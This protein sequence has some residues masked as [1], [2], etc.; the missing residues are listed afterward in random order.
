MR[1]WGQRFRED[2]AAAAFLSASKGRP[3]A[4]IRLKAGDRYSG[5]AK[6]FRSPHVQ[7]NL[8]L[9]AGAGWTNGRSREKQPG[10]RTL[11]K[12]VRKHIWGEM[13]PPGGCGASSSLLI[14]MLA[15]SRIHSASI[16]SL[17]SGLFSALLL[18]PLSSRTLTSAPR[19]FYW[20]KVDLFR[21]LCSCW[22]GCLLQACFVSAFSLHSFIFPLKTPPSAS[23]RRT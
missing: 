11:R 12:Y 2:R 13:A 14:Y 8:N 15:W 10:S 16:L 22:W 21:F 1:K 7:K 18:L 3:T 6:C 5:L 20:I 9:Y 17:I 4:E 19:V 23:P